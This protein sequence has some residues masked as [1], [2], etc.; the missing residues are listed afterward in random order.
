[1]SIELTRLVESEGRPAVITTGWW[2]VQPG[3]WNIVPGRVRFGVDLRHPD[4]LTKQRLSGAARARYE[5]RF[6]PR[7]AA[8]R[9]VAALSPLVARPSPEPTPRGA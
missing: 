2:D 8:E 5:E 1:M 9:L 7:A 6:T 3:A 4:A